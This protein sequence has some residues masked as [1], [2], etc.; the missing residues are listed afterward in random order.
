MLAFGT[1]VI[2]ACFY[3]VKLN[4]VPDQFWGLLKIGIGGYIGGRSLEKITSKVTENVD[5]TFLKKKDR[6]NS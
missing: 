6:K 3:N 4:E 1:I 5:L 2:I